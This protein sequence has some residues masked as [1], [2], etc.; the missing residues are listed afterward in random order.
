MYNEKEN[1]GT[2]RDNHFDSHNQ[3]YEE[4]GRDEI[5]SIQ[6][7]YSFVNAIKEVFRMQG[8]FHSANTFHI[9][10]HGKIF[11]TK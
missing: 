7:A 8:V 1:N 5:F 10:V 9:M 2:T 6:C 11:I 4:L 3:I